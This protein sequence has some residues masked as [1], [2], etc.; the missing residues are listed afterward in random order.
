MRAGCCVCS[1]AY[2]V[3]VHLR[4]VCGG[5][6]AATAKQGDAN[7]SVAML[8]GRREDYDGKLGGIIIRL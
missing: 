5:Q 7:N 2:N 3:A 1:I 4:Q 8:K 6:V